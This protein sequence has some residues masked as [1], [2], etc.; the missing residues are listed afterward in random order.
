MIYY[1]H[2]FVSVMEADMT[3]LYIVCGYFWI[4]NYINI[5]KLLLHRLQETGLL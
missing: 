3:L 1:D 5:V 4:E 2:V